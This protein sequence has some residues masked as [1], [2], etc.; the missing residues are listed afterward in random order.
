M[1]YKMYSIIWFMESN[2]WLL[3]VLYE[4]TTILDL[5]LSNVQISV[6]KMY[7]NECIL[8]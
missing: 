3:Y 8:P 7:A 2:I 5:A 1:Y 6:L 4:L